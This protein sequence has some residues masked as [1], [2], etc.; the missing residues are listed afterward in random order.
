MGCGV[1][2]TATKQPDISDD[3]SD[4]PT[5][6]VTEAPQED[7][8]EFL[9]KAKLL[10][11]LEKDQTLLYAAKLFVQQSNF[12]SAKTSL[13]GIDAELA[14]PDVLRQVQIL[15]ARIAL[16]RGEARLA[17]KL[18]PFSSILPKDQ[19]I[20][21]YKIRAQ[22]FLDAGYPL[23]AAKTRVQMDSLLTDEADIKT[24]HQAIWEALSLL[25]ET[26]LNQISLAPL[27]PVFLGWIELAKVAKRGQIDWQH[28]QEG[29]IRWRKQYPTH[30]A[31]KVFIAELGEKQIELMDRPTHIAVMLPL[32][33]RYAQVASAIQ[34][35]FMT[36]YY[37]HPDKT[38]RPQISFIDTGK[39]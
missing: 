1:K 25:P 13:Q 26:T 19:Q 12:E 34:D 9:E 35:G 20:E 27:H 21:V 39:N 24:N 22:A 23:E 5:D 32:S 37:Q 4:T 11:G 17:L 10:T 15:S 3:I 7:P 2:P 14:A 6:V 33:G 36:A 30:P 38:L 18:L 31:A 8:Y 16:G 29:I 28:L